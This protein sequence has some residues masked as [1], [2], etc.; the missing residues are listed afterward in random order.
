MREAYREAKK[1]AEDAVRKANREGV[2]PYLPVLDEIVSQA[3]IKNEVS[4]GLIE[5]PISRIV[6]NKERGRNNAF[7]NNFM[8]LFDDGTEFAIKW[9]NLHDSVMQEGVRDAIKVYEYMNDYYVQEG[10]KRVSVSLYCESE[11]LTCDVTRLIP[12][13]SDTKEYKVYQEYLKFYEATGNYIIVLSE[14]GSYQ[15]LA[16]LIG[17]DL[18]SQWPEDLKRDLKFAFYRF[19]KQYLKLFPTDGEKESSSA[20]FL[21]LMIFPFKTILGD[22]DDQISS[23]IKMS[24]AELQVHM[25]FDDLLTLFEAPE[26]VETVSGLK[27]L[28]T[29]KKEYTSSKPLRVGFVYD[30][31]IEQ[32]RWIDSHEAGRLYVEEMMDDNV[33]TSCYVAD[34]STGVKDALDLAVADKCEVIFTVTQD[35][36]ADAKRVA[37]ENPGLKL[38]NCSAGQISPS[39]RCYEGRI[40][41]ATFLT[42][43]LAADLMLNHSAGNERKIGYV[44]RTSEN[45]SLNAFAI[46]VSMIAPDCRVIAISGE[47]DISTQKWTERGVRFYADIEYPA[48]KGALPRSGLYEIADGKNVHIATPYYSW[49]K[50]YVII[51][52]AVLSGAWDINELL[53]NRNAANYWFGLNMGVVELRAPRIPHTTA[54]LISMLKNSIVNGYDPFDGE[55]YTKDG[56][57]Q[58]SSMEKITTEKLLNMD[59]I[60]ANIEIG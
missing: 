14:P 18:D 8:P 50:F 6:G 52:Q 26:A 36:L 19:R 40:Y 20:F 24:S 31:D 13:E 55:I 38:L 39:V 21:Y 7:A 25:N 22:T 37:V 30:C 58:T 35:M 17:H 27:K 44:R 12:V 49:G 23:N 42:G 48:Q 51:V 57:L 28:L 59:W 33:V 54:K 32:S 45:A 46:G 4:L 1:R 15:K 9:S 16:D 10:N 34:E 43:V 11:F 41:E 3:Q 47:D 60:N 56:P 29:G 5:L 53:K 2:D